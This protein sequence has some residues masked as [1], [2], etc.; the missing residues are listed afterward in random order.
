M[1]HELKL[2]FSGDCDNPNMAK[3]KNELLEEFFNLLNSFEYNCK[4]ANERLLE[5]L[6]NKMFGIY[7][8]IEIMQTK[9]GI[10]LKELTIQRNKLNRQISLL[11]KG[12]LEN[13]GS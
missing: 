7:D 9:E 13:G 4:E 8:L 3:L 6:K 1:E 10:K 5:H 12:T 2:K 11:K